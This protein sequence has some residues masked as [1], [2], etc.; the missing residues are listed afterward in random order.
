MHSDIRIQKP[1]RYQKG[2]MKPWDEGAE[3]LQISN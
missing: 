1:S 3:A 2:K